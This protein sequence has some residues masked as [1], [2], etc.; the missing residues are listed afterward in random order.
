MSDLTD[1]TKDDEKVKLLTNKWKE[2][3]KIHKKHNYSL[4]IAITFLKLK[5]Q[6]IF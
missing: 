3:V 4:E 2:L 1:G 6:V 5:N